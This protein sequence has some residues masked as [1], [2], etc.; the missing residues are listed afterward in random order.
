MWEVTNMKRIAVVFLVLLTLLSCFTACSLDPKQRKYEKALKFIKKEQYE[1]AYEIFIALGDYKDSKAFAGKFYYVMTKK[2]ESK[3]V[4]DGL[5]LRTQVDVKEYVYNRDG[6]CAEQI[7]YPHGGGEYSCRLTYDD[8]GN[9][10]KAK[11]VGL[12]DNTRILEFVNNENGDVTKMDDYTSGELYRSIEYSYDEARRMVKKVQTYA[13]S[14]NN[15]TYFHT[16]D[17]NGGLIKTV[18]KDVTGDRSTS[19]Y[20]LTY[21]DEKRIIKK[22]YK[23]LRD[24]VDTTEYTYNE[25]GY[26]VKIKFYDSD[27]YKEITEHTYDKNGNLSETIIWKNNVKDETTRYIYDDNG[28]LKRK[29]VK[30]IHEDPYITYYYYDSNGNLIKEVLTL[31]EKIKH[32]TEIEYKLVYMPYDFSALS[33][34]TNQVMIELG[35][36]YRNALGQS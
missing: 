3:V 18:W 10:I 19:T 17:E 1:E 12:T 2:T 34:I 5:G 13:K 8:K 27:D 11:S 14:G 15:D 22:V 32:T 21:D 29:E 26:L 9:L 31:D 16:Y 36:E 28:Y 24:S 7:D 20:D 4:H 30:G 23:R 35:I 6:M 25:K 33:F